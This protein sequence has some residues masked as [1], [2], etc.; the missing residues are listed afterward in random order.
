VQSLKYA[1]RFIGR[2]FQ[3]AKEHEIL[4]KPWMYLSLGN[5]GLL[6][7]WFIPLALVVGLI[8]LRPIGQVLIGLISILALFSWVVWGEITALRTSQIFNALLQ[9]EGYDG[10]GGL[11][12]RSFLKYWGE[13]FILML[14][15]PGLWLLYGIRQSFSKL[16]HQKFEWLDVLALI[17]P[18]IVLEDLNLTNSIN[19]VKQILEQHLLRIR[20]V[21]IRVAFIAHLVQWLLVATGMLIGFVIGMFIADP[22]TSG[23]WRMI[24]G[25]GAGLLI[26]WAFTTLGVSFSTFSR[27][28]YHTALYQWASRTEKARNAGTTEQATPPLILSQV[29]GAYSSSKKEV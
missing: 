1:F 22:L 3:L 23:R 11:D 29:L 13:V 5:F 8:G 18:V 28:C 26:G 12:E 10:V 25:T 16:N 7:L 9:D 15:K 2:S 27:A 24:I 6:I 17:Q 21:Y 4:Q 20:P 19:R 14:S